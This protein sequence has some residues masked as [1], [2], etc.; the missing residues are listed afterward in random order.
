MWFKQIQL[1][2][3]KPIKEAPDA[4]LEKINDL[5]FIPCF[6]STPSSIGWVSP[7]DQDESP[8]IRTINGNIMLCMQIE[9]KILP[10]TVIKQELEA[11]IK[12]LESMDD[13]KVRS[14][15]KATLKDEMI[16]TL[17][18]KAFSKLSRVYGYIDNKNNWLVLNTTN[19]KVTE[20][21]ISLFKKS[22]SDDI[23][24]I[25]IKEFKSSMTPWVKFEQ[26]PSDF[27]I[28]NACILQDPEHASRIIRCQ[29]QNLFAKPIQDLLKEGCEVIQLSL[30]W[31]DKINF[32]LTSEFILKSIS[33][34]DE[35][36]EQVK[37]MDPETDEQRFDADFYIMAELFSL[38]LNELLN[39]FSQP[40]QI[41]QT[42]T[43]AA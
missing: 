24:P 29:Q 9:E 7:I 3:I 6:P 31:Q 17:L 2:N 23:E 15:E 26:Y 42:K 22:I 10:A 1:F 43:E 27:G 8:L 14:K 5:S 12:K 30:S 35:I 4:L 32:V 40:A 36:H 34:V 33:V 38:L 16:V 19:K 28:E 11:K 18:P 25:D 41:P 13:R 37:E 21:F 20:Q 39:T